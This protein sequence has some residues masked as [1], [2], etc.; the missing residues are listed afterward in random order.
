LVA[1]TE[2]DYAQGRFVCIDQIEWPEQKAITAWL[3]GLSFP[4][5]L[6]R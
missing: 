6:A 3:K 5:H 1:L 2:K 4:V